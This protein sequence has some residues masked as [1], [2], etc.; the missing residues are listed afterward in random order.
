V[1]DGVGNKLREA[2]ARRR[3]SLQEVE[4]AT[5]IRGR[6]LQ[7]IEDEDWE[8]L[9]SATYARAF[10]RTYASLVGLDGERLA[11]EQRQAQGAARPGERLPRVDPKPR[12]VARG[13]RRRVPPRALAVVV[14]LAVLAALLAVGLTSGGGSGGD[15]GNGGHK[16]PAPHVGQAVPVR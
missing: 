10:I 5:K 3:L 4:E 8:Q 16:H 13:R 11:E 6:Y 2:R 15:S 9:P 1:D 12:P 14:T 7:A